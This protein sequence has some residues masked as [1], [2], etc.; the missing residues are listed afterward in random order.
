MR[1]ELEVTLDKGQASPRDLR[2]MGEVVRTAVARSERLVDCLLTLAESE[3]GLARTEPVDLAELA[4]PALSQAAAAARQAG[5]HVTTT[6][7]LAS[8]TGTRVLLERL[9]ENLADNGV[10]HNRPGGW[11]TIRTASHGDTTE[12]TAE[13]SGP[14]ITPREAAS[15]FEPFR[16][17][18]A[19][20][21]GS[22]HGSG[23]G[24]SIVR[25]VAQAHGGN[26]TATPLAEGGL[27]V[28]VRL[29]A[30]PPPASTPQQLAAAQP[31]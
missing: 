18:H 7:A 1:T 2:A 26:A 24:L 3:R 11:L 21:L 4:P 31:K 17:L 30:T 14:H 23:L 27:R 12:L 28:T 29:P 19:D 6:L 15:L 22:A 10:R 13:N 5:I 9:I 25:A 8:V 16:R 20:R